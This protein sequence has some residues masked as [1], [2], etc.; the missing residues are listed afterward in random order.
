MSK[1]DYDLA[2]GVKEI[3]TDNATISISNCNFNSGI[4]SIEIC[5][6]SN[7]SK[8]C[9]AFTVIE[10]NQVDELKFIFKPSK[11]NKEIVIRTPTEVFVISNKTIQKKYIVEISKLIISSSGRSNAGISI[12]L[13]AEQLE[14]I[15]DI[16]IGYIS[17]GCV[18]V[19]KKQIK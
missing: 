6:S 17:L 9:I 8:A 4:G 16:L 11:K 19:K 13:N 2:P 5:I 12:I 18:R 14:D 1:N 7:K 3:K 15:Y 10:E